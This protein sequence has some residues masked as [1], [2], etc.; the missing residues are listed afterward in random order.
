MCSYL[1]IIDLHDNSLTGPIR[2]TV[3]DVSDNKL[4][5]PIPESGNL[6]RFNVSSFDGNK[7]LYGYPLGPM[8]S[9]ELSVLAIVAIGL[10]SGLLSLVLS[11]MVVYVWLRSVE[12]KRGVEEEGKV[13]NM[14]PDY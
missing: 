3:F 6:R 11:F 10:G 4:S 14:M 13:Q 8:K 9:K 7:G 1:N 5:G 12:K 2:L